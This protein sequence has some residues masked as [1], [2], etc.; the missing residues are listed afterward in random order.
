MG[1]RNFSSE[2]FNS[3]LKYAF[4]FVFCAQIAKRR[5]G[6]Q[7]TNGPV[8]V[9]QLADRRPVTETLVDDQVFVAGQVN[10]ETFLFSLFLSYK[11]NDIKNI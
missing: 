11:S 4:G 3:K 9:V 2:I 7:K 6:Q 10:R 5:E 8:D 1:N